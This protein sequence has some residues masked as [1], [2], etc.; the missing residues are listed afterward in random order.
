MI[1]AAYGT[2]GNWDIDNLVFVSKKLK[3]PGQNCFASRVVSC[4]V[5]RKCPG[6]APVRSLERSWCNQS[7]MQSFNTKHKVQYE[8]KIT[9]NSSFIFSIYLFIHLV[10]VSYPLRSIFFLFLHAWIK[11]RFEILWHGRLLCITCHLL[12]FF[13]TF[14]F[15]FEVDAW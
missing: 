2:C 5:M 11:F 13:M 14:T 1:V 9:V 12:G 15:C 8:I 10:W 3:Y 7:I 4:S 6:H